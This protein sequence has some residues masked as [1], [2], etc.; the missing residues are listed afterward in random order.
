MAHTEGL[1]RAA[2]DLELSGAFP[3]WVEQRLRPPILARA[4]AL[5]AADE[6]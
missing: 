5:K 6:N 2:S 3:F 1:W 4:Q